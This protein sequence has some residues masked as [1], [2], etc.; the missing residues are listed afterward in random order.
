MWQKQQG[1]WDRHF[2]LLKSEIIYLI[3]TRQYQ[4]EGKNI[5]EKLKKLKVSL[6]FLCPY[7][8]IHFKVISQ[9]LIERQNTNDVVKRKL[10]NCVSVGPTYSS[11]LCMSTAFVSL[12]CPDMFVHIYKYIYNI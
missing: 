6:C 5:L 8:K 1:V 12:Q 7:G 4:E 9:V 3:R 10:T 2:T 11:S